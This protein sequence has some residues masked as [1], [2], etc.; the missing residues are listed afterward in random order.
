LVLEV[1]VL[2]VEAAEVT[3]VVHVLLEAL[4]DELP[5]SHCYSIG[6]L[7]REDQRHLLGRGLV[8]L[9]KDPIFRNLS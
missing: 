4:C 5:H 2:E 1:K 7:Q 9:G 8:V 6:I 3:H